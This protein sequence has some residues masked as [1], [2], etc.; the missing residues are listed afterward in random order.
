MDSKLKRIGALWQKESDKGIYYTGV[1]E[2][3]FD[4]TRVIIFSNKYKKNDKSPD[5]IVY[6]SEQT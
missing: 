3:T 6:K 5:F 4:E 1:I 2:P